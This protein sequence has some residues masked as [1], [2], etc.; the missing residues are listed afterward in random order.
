MKISATE[1][2][3]LRIL[4]RIAQAGEAGMSI[5]QLSAAEGLSEP[6]IG[7]LT[8]LLRLSGFVA[9]TRGQKGGYV[10]AMPPKDIR[11]GDVLKSLDGSLF[12]DDFCAS[13]TGVNA[14]CTH[15][16]DCTVKSLWRSVQ[17]NVDTLLQGIT[18]HDLIHQP[19][20]KAHAHVLSHEV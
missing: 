9:S 14:L 16:L 20:R 18:L 4:M 6:Y 8:R 7:K 10:L 12:D 13:H 19:M 11:I 5:P 3:G 1:E 17:H 15:S 2:Y